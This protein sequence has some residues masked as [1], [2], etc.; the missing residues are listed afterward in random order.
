MALKN[1]YSPPPLSLQYDGRCSSRSWSM[2]RAPRKA[3]APFPLYRCPL[4]DRDGYTRNGYTVTRNGCREGGGGDDDDD[5]GG[6][7]VVQQSGSIDRTPGDGAS[8]VLAGARVLGGGGCR[9]DD[10]TTTMTTMTTTTR[11][12]NA[13][14]VRSSTR[15][16]PYSGGGALGRVR[17][18]R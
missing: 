15:Y 2:K 6:G 7:G 11:R 5:D 14:A 13:V 16:T 1:P 8:G 10:A 3:C 12:R 17:D 9:R 4:K 18:Q